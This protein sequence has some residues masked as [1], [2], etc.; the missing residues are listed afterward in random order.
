MKKIWKGNHN[1]LFWLGFEKKSE[2]VLQN[3]CTVAGALLSFRLCFFHLNCSSALISFH[4]LQ[5][6]GKNN[7]SMP[8]HCV[9]V[10]MFQL[11]FV[12]RWQPAAD[13]ISS[14]VVVNI[15]V[16]GLL[17][18]LT[19]NAVHGLCLV[20]ILLCFTLFCRFCT[21]SVRLPL[22]VWVKCDLLKV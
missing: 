15:S 11:V 20:I 1:S 14:Y 19:Q 3:Q 17:T 13:H 7:L 6:T 22:M 5:Y 2:A 10:W 4:H 12:L 8:V 21:L 9:S 16:V 18:T